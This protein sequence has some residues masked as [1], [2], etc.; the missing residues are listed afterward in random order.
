MD[1][2]LPLTPFAEKFISISAV[3]IFFYAVYIASP[4]VIPDSIFA[5]ADTSSSFLRPI[6]WVISNLNFS[7]NWRKN[8][9][10]AN[11]YALYPSAINL[12]C[13]AFHESVHSTMKETRCNRTEERKINLWL[14]ALR[15]TAKRNL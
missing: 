11:G 12:K 8:C 6:T 15:N 2:S 10:A 4:F 14:L 9:C 7:P 1:G 13:T 5:L 3:Y